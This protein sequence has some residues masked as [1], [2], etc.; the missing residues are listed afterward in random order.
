[1]AG[2]KQC[3]EVPTGLGVFRIVSTSLSPEIYTPERSNAIYVVAL[4]D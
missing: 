4:Q 2:A 3:V 1:M